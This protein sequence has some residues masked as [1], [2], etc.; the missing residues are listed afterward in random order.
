MGSINLSDLEIQRPKKFLQKF[1]ETAIEDFVYKDVKLDITVGDVRNSKVGNIQNNT[2]DIQ[3]LTDFD[4]IRQ[5]ITNIFNTTPGEKLLNP[6]LG[7]NLQQYIFMPVTENTGKLI[8]ETILRG[9]SK[10]EPRVNVEKVQIVGYPDAHEFDITLIL[11]LPNL[12]NKR[13]AFNG[14]LNSDGINLR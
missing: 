9:L 3:D 5:S 1:S 2:V 4:A 13:T 7:I 8:A 10:Q 14:I 12:N 11:S 6:Y